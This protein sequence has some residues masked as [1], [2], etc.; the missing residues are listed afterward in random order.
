MAAARAPYIAHLGH[1]DL[2]YPTHLEHLLSVVEE[3]SADFVNTLLVNLG[4][5]DHRTLQPCN[6]ARSDRAAAGTCAPVGLSHQTP[7]D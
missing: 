4:A 3:N 2:W 7:P 6:Q 1:D 5:H